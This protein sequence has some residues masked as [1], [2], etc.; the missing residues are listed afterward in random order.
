MLGTPSAELLRLGGGPA[1]SSE[2]ALTKRSLPAIVLLVLLSV[3]AQAIFLAGPARPGLPLD[4]GWIQATYA[5][6]LAREGQLCLNRG[7]PST[8]TT[9]FLGMALPAALCLVGIGP[10]A[11]P[12]AWAVPLQ[13]WL[14]VVCFLL[15]RDAGLGGRWAFAAAASCALLGNLVW[16]SLAG[17]ET[18]LFLVLALSAIWCRSRE[19]FAAA[20]ILAGL[21]VLTRPEGAALALAMGLAELPALWRKQF[22][23]W[24]IWLRLFL[25]VAIAAAIYV[26]M[27]LAV[28]GQPLTSSYAGRRWLAGQPAAIDFGPAAVLAR[29]GGFA[30]AWFRYLYR[31]VFGTVLLAWLNVDS[32]ALAGAVTSVAVIVVA[33]GGMVGLLAGARRSEHSSSPLPMLLGWTLLHN[34]A[35]VV[36]LPVHGHAGRYQAVN[37]VVVA[38]LATAGIAHLARLRTPAR[39]LAPPLLV[40]WLALC[41]GS[42]MLWRVIYR[43]SVDHINTTHVGC[44]RWIAEHL[45]ADAVVA[46]YDLGA[47]A[48]FAERPIVDIGGLTDPDMAPYLFAGN[49]TPYMRAKGATHL[50]MVQHAVTDQALLRGLGIV[51]PAPGR[52]RLH[53]LEVWLVPAERYHLH[54]IATSNSAPLMVLYRLEWPHTPAAD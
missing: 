14:V 29:A 49:C 43:D 8:G 35:Y 41:L 48:Y 7:E 22:G 3:G 16:L 4:D 26:A 51:P 32:A 13:A 21:L 9:S 50:A 46:T 45:P 12:L 40:L 34:A 27:N 44:G 15:V 1:P 30:E 20:G 25:P 11:A 47:I 6:N 2:N 23:R 10:V 17:M 38:V 53:L 36:F 28:T 19:R 31:W 33:L 5:R 37:F 18:T 39:R 42:T 54:H 52:P 24:P